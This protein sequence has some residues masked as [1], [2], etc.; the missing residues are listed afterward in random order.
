MATIPIPSVGLLPPEFWESVKETSPEDFATAYPVPF[1]LELASL[2]D[3]EML[4][5]AMGEEPT[6]SASSNSVA[7]VPTK[8]WEQ[9][10]V[11]TIEKRRATT[12]ATHI[13]VG[14]SANNDIVVPSPLV[15]KLHAAFEKQGEEWT[16]FDV[17]SRNGTTIANRGLAP[18]EPRPIDI[19]AE[20]GFGDTR[21]LF[22]PPLFFHH[23]V[24]TLLGKQPQE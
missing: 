14:R 11:V 3:D 21:F 20:I 6:I 24:T 10:R 19:G 15:S 18:N 16:V 2:R 23:A 7:G 1:L 9:T 4:D 8:P 13:T 5:E 22:V 12:P 17:G